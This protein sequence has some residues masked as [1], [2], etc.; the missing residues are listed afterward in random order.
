M[1]P[2]FAAPSPGYRPRSPTNALKEIWETLH[3]A[4]SIKWQLLG[5][6]VS[7]VLARLDWIG[8]ELIKR[9]I[10]SPEER[11]MILG[12]PSWILGLT[13]ILFF[14]FVWSFNYAHRLRTKI[15]KSRV[16]L[17]V[18]RARGVR[19]RNFGRIKITDEECLD[20]WIFRTNEWHKKVYEEIRHISVADAEWFNVM[21]FVPPPRLPFCT[22]FDANTQANLVAKHARRFSQH[23]FQVFRLGE[24]IR[25]LWGK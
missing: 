19:L 11:G 23:D 2:A 16:S 4:A 25:D 3:A 14:L 8:G 9:G 22:P 24:M 10:M 15:Q 12:F 13:S 18:L 6:F 17:S 1:P 7:I 21:D 20:R 5:V